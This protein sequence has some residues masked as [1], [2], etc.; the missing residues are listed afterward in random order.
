M[1]IS[2]M[3][4][5]FILNQNDFFFLQHFFSIAFQDPEF[6]T[7]TTISYFF[8]EQQ[9]IMFEVYDVDSRSTRFDYLSKITDLY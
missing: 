9:H 2:L 8:E 7:K 5:F 3:T 6:A 4:N 1:S